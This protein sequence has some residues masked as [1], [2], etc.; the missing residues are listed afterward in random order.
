MKKIKATLMAVVAVL[1][2][3]A[4]ISQVSAVQIGNHTITFVGP[5]SY[6][7]DTCISTWTYEVTSSSQPGEGL[8]HWAMQWCNEG[9]LV[10]CS[11]KCEYGTH[12]H[13][14]ITGIKIEGEYEGGTPKTV[15]FELEGCGDYNEG[16]REVCIKAGTNPRVCGYVTGPMGLDGCHPIPE[17]TTIAIPVAAILGLLFFFNQRKRRKAK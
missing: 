2:V 15:W 10:R 1:A 8:S 5:H 6:D 14:E 11:E 17:F 4:F 16:D 9:A 3:I 12:S 7:P 13:T